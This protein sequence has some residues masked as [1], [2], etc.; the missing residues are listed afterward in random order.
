MVLEMLLSDMPDAGY[1]WADADEAR[2]RTA[3]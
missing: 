3:S 1:K 2:C